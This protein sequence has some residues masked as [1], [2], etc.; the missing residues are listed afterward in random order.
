MGQEV[1]DF[2]GEE[3]STCGGG[4]VVGE[5]AGRAAMLPWPRPL[6]LTAGGQPLESLLYALFVFTFESM[7]A[8]R[9][10]ALPAAG[11]W[12]FADPMQC[13]EF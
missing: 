8:I 2:F 4:G 7:G 1:E 10:A 3:P 9:C 12:K 11:P 13:L 6:R 5:G